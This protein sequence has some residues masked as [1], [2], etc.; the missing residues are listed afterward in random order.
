MKATDINEQVRAIQTNYNYTLHN[1]CI[2][3]NVQMYLYT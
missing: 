2:H 1:M 3:F